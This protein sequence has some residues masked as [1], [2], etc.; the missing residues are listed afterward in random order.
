MADPRIYPLIDVPHEQLRNMVR[1]PV[2]NIER[3]E[4]GFTNTIH[5]VTLASGQLLAVKHY[6]AGAESF[7]AELAT[8]TLLH[9]SL[10]VPDITHVDDQAFAIVYKWIDGVTLNDLRASG[11]ST[12]FASI[13]EPL[14]RL[15]AWLARTDATEPFELA[16]ILERT[17]QQLSTGKT[18]QRLGAPLCDVLRKAFESSE[19][20]LAWGTV[21]LAHGDLGLRNLIVQPAMKERW[22]ISGVIDWEATTTCSPLLDI[23]SLFRYR[24]RYDQAWV[25]GFARGYREA[26]GELPEDWLRTAR[27]LDATWAIETL[28]EP[29]ELP[30]VYAD[31]KE[32][33]A[34]LAADL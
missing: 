34:R 19:P 33:L 4:G 3:V 29:R 15:M 5:K 31:C 14:G 32:L 27:L 21:C 16:P 25:D 1:A 7:G 17:Y 2:K 12:G 23:G 13:A 26:D 30:G 8:L 22:R 6:A 11:P 28:D 24:H 18:R 20:Q 10:P 9:G